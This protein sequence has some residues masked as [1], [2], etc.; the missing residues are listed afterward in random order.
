MQLL[1]SNTSDL[2]NT[3]TLDEE[4]HAFGVCVGDVWA[5][6]RNRNASDPAKHRGT[7]KTIREK[8]RDLLGSEDLGSWPQ[9]HCFESEFG[10]GTG[11]WLGVGRRPRPITSTEGRSV[12]SWRPAT[13]LPCL[14]TFPSFETFLSLHSI[15]SN[16]WSILIWKMW[17]HSHSLLSHAFS[18]ILLDFLSHCKQ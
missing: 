18:F 9:G 2:A 1:K 8:I 3:N 10:F 16:H 4:A 13:P 12:I 17:R 14:Y 15:Y 6:S 5:E 11:E 7:R